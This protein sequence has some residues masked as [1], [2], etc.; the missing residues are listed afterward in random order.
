M[1]DIH[2]QS[3][4]QAVKTLILYACSC[5]MFYFTK[6][7]VKQELEYTISVFAAGCE[8]AFTC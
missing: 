5:L 7:K 6:Q 2:T 3:I 4:K 8:Y 1:T